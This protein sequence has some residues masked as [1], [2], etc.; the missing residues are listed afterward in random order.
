MWILVADSS[1]ARFFDAN[2]KF[3]APGEF[4]FSEFSEVNDLVNSWGRAKNQDINTDKPGRMAD[5]TG[6]GGSGA[7]RSAVG[8]REEPKETEA[9]AFAQRV[10]DELEEKLNENAY[11]ELVLVAAP[12]FLGML[13]DA[14]GAQVK[15]A[16][17]EEISKDFTKMSAHD[18][19][20]RLPEVMS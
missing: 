16:V 12:K 5:R 7:Q 1:R 14:I 4:E 18:L 17:I 20:G 6:R 10:A 3:S 11:D 13:R 8:G 9:K 2:R 15:G 19:Q